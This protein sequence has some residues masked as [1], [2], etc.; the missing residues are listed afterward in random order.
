VDCDVDADP[1]LELSDEELARLEPDTDEPDGSIDFSI[2]GEITSEDTGQ[3]VPRS[4]EYLFGSRS[5]GERRTG[6][7]GLDAGRRV[8]DQRRVR[9]RFINRIVA[10]S[11]Q[12]HS[13]KRIATELNRAGVRTA[14]GHQWTPQAIG[15]LLRAEGARL[16]RRAWLPQALVE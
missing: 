4:G 15:Q 2:D 1:A 12:G 9:R 8:D 11:D 6:E 13:A 10:L 3:L 14:R 16:E 7:R 5:S